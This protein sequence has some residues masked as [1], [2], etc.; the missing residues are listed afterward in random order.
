MD[1]FV[2]GRKPNFK[3]PRSMP[4][5]FSAERSFR[6]RN[7]MILVVGVILTGILTKSTL[8]T[9]LS[10][11]LKD[12]RDETDARNIAILTKLEERGDRFLQLQRQQPQGKH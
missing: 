10:K 9:V 12:K 6:F 1:K 3:I 2:P 7:P 8:A 4:P 11:Y 5:P